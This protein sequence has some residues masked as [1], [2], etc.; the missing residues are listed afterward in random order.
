MGTG[1]AYSFVMTSPFA[2]IS[3]GSLLS[4]APWASDRQKRK[5]EMVT[6]RRK[7]Q[8]DLPVLHPDD[9][10]IDVG[11]SELFVAVPADRDPRT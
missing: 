9:A 10:G 2:V 5:D 7:K 6:K 11:A 1:V 4:F 3:I 8:E